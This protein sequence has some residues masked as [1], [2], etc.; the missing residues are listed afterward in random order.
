M[1]CAATVYCDLGPKFG[2]LVRKYLTSL[3]IESSE[4]RWSCRYKG[5]SEVKG[6]SGSAMDFFPLVMLA[7]SG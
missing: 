2:L 7:L 4:V 6:Y 5:I 3:G 1:I